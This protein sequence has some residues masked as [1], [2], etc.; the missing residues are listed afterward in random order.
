MVFQAK[1]RK[2]NFKIIFKKNF[3]G[4][5]ELILVICQKFVAIAARIAII[6]F[7]KFPF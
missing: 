5:V 2:I 4:L 6:R 1:S 7:S 3:I